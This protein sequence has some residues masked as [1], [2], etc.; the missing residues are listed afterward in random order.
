MNSASELNITFWFLD[1]QS[2]SWLQRS[3][4]VYKHNRVHELKTF[5][6][7]RLGEEIAT[8]SWVYDGMILEDKATLNGK[9]PS[10]MCS[11][12]LKL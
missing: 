4:L 2:K 10:P 11:H 9:K 5:L 8:S 12:S 1:W 3:A 7:V 6:R